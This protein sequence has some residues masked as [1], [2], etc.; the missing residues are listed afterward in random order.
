L[1]ALTRGDRKILCREM[2][3]K[4]SPRRKSAI[5]RG[6]SIRLPPTNA[7]LLSK[8]VGKK[9]EKTREEGRAARRHSEPKRRGTI[10]M[11]R[12]DTKQSAESRS[13]TSDEKSAAEQNFESENGKK[14]TALGGVIPKKARGYSRQAY[15]GD[16]EGEGD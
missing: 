8:I 13:I 14:E 3:Q 9:L 7:L 6:G 11:V 2:G 12:P 1:R 16:T 4:G 5:S 10:P 15:Q